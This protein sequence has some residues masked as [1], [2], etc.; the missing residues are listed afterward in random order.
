[1]SIHRHVMINTEREGGVKKRDGSRG[2]CAARP[3]YR[4]VSRCCQTNIQRRLSKRLSSLRILS[5]LS[6]ASAEALGS[7]YGLCSRGER[8]ALY[9]L[10]S[11]ASTD[12]SLSLSLCMGCPLWSPQ[13]T[14]PIFSPM[15][16]ALVS[17]Y[18]SV[19]VCV[20]VCV[21]MRGWVCMCGS[22]MAMLS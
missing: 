18:E 5:P 9:R 3:T 12:A 21:C 17:L 4:S 14:V 16:K 19:C 20:C 2:A 10:S 6:M 22:L 11:P 15:P 1:M 13:T 7:L 8:E